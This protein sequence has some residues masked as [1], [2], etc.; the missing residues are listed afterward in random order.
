THLF[1][2]YVFDSKV[3]LFHLDT[4]ESG[5]HQAITPSIDQTQALGAIE[6]ENVKVRLVSENVDEGFSRARARATISACNEMV[7][8]MRAAL[9]MSVAYAKDRVQFSRPIGSFQAIKH[10]CADMILETE[11]SQSIAM[12]GAWLA[13]AK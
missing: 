3:S 6:C 10:K 8:T 9:D 7:G 1:F 2:P 11:S 13:S 4:R 12:Y 5:V